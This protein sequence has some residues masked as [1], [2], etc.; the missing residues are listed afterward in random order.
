MVFQPL[1]LDSWLFK[2]IGQW[3]FFSFFKLDFDSGIRQDEL[4][5]TRQ[6]ICFLVF[7]AFSTIE[8]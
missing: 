1:T 8:L 7:H 3:L 6:A 5:I 4:K 2:W